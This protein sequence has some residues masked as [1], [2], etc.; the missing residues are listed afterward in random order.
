MQGGSL[1]PHHPRHC[2]ATLPGVQD[3]GGN[4][5]WPCPPRLSP[6]LQ[7]GEWGGQ[8]ITHPVA[9]QPETF[10][11]ERRDGGS[12]PSPAVMPQRGPGTSVSL[13]WLQGRQWRN[14]VWLSRGPLS[15]EMFKSLK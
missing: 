13:L 4:V 10:Q 7:T 5:G 6:E 2:H 15:A 12:P 11:G 1:P 14:D 9:L 3:G 8:P